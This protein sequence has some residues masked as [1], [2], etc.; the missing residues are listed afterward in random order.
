MNIYR[1]HNKG[2]IVDKQNRQIDRTEMVTKSNMKDQSFYIG[3][4]KRSSIRAR[5]KIMDRH[6]VL[7]Y[8]VKQKW[9]ELSRDEAS[10]CALVLASKAVYAEKQDLSSLNF[11]GM[12]L[13][14]I[15]DVTIKKVELHVDKVFARD[16]SQREKL[17]GYWGDVQ[18]LKATGKRGVSSYSGIKRYLQK[19]YNCDV[20][21]TLIFDTWHELENDKTKGDK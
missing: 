12:T 4:M 9:P 15:R 21:T 17:L 16:K 11:D 6:R 8:K 10:Y 19:E 5:I 14:N 18:M 7:I 20:G 1:T 13:D 2:K 3:F